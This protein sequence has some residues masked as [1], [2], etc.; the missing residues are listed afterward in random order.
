MRVAIVVADNTV[1]LDGRPVGVDLSAM[2]K[3]VV[4]V[5]WD[6]SRGQVEYTDQPPAVIDSLDDYARFVDAARAEL[7]RVIAATAMTPERAAAEV[8]AAI[9]QRKIAQQGGP[10][11]GFVL[12]QALLNMRARCLTMAGRKPIPTPPPHAG[13]WRLDDGSWRRMTCRQLIDTVARIEDRNG[14]LWAAARAHMDQVDRMVA[15]GATVDEIRQ[16]DYSEGL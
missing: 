6:G 11:D 9:R 4:A 16:Y 7:D 2:P 1:Y 5:Q 8:K 10:M 3:G 14:L 12:D 13:E 15:A